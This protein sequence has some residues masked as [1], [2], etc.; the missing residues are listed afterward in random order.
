MWGDQS[1][2]SHWNHPF[3]IR[4]G[5][6]SRGKAISAVSSAALYRCISAPLLFRESLQGGLESLKTAALNTSNCT[7]SGFLT[8]TDTSSLGLL[9]LGIILSMHTSCTNQ[10]VLFVLDDVPASRVHHCE[11]QGW[12][13]P[14]YKL[15]TTQSAH[16]RTF[17]ASLLWIYYFRFYQ[18]CNVTLLRSCFKWVWL[19]W[20]HERNT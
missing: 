16:R 10:R 17:E 8:L 5:A 1:F 6:L 4:N 3:V 2:S 9:S 20:Y 12:L 7:M 11:M 14:C 18:R 13:P 15:K 19:L